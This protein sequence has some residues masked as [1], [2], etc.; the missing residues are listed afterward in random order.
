MNFVVRFAGREATLTLERTE[1]GYRAAVDGH[2][3]EVDVAPANGALRSLLIAGRQ[4]EVAAFSEG[5]GC[6]RVTTATG[7]GVVELMDPLTHLARQ[8]QG[9]AAAA[10]QHVVTAYMPG[11]VVKILVVQDNEVKAGQGLIVL[12]AMK[13]ENEIQAER[14]G[15]VKRV[16][17]TEGQA[18]EGGD[19]LF[20]MG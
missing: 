6:Y 18:V 7:E 15:V 13:M 4:F 8:A 17:V 11:R 20:E 16:L 19:P 2:T 10:G 1:R 5:N 14:D 9:N 12:E 3:Y